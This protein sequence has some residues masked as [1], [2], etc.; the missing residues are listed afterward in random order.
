GGGA[1]KVDLV[2]SGP[3]PWRDARL[4]GAGTVHLGGTAAD[5]A[6]TE[7]AVASGHHAERPVVLVSQPWVADPDRVADDGRRPLWTYAHVP[8]HS[9]RDVTEDVLRALEEV[10][11]GIRDVVLAAHCTPASRMVE[12]NANYAGG[13]IAAGRVDLAGLLARPVPRR[14]PYATG[15]PGI[16]HASASTPPGPGVHGMAGNHVAGRILAR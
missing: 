16:W 6:A 10:A 12:H 13:D 5:I 4:A 3:V 1:A 14:D 9:D 11:P 15:L 8:T 7:R 2:L